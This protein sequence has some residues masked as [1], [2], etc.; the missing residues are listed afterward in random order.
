MRRNRRSL[1]HAGRSQRGGNER[2]SLSTR[3]IY[4]R[5]L[6]CEAL[7][8]RRLLGAYA[9][10][11]VLYC[12]DQNGKLCTISK[13]NGKVAVIGTMSETMTDIAF[14][15]KGL[16][17][18]IGADH[19]LYRI[20]PSNA[21]TS[22]IGYFSPD[23]NSLVFRSDGTLFAAGGT[24]AASLYT[25]N[26]STANTTLIGSL[27]GYGTAG[28]LA[29]GPSGRL[30]VT[31]TT[32]KLLRVN[33]SNGACTFIGKI[34]FDQVY[35]LAF[36]KDGT[37]YAVSNASEHLLRINT[38]TGEGWALAKFWGDDTVGAYGAD[39]WR[40]SPP[41]ISITD[42]AMTEGDS[43]TKT[44]SFKVSLTGA[45]VLG[46]S[47]NY[48]TS[49]GTATAG[50]DYDA[51]PTTTL[52]WAANT[53]GTKTVNVT[54]HGDTTVEWD[55]TFYVDLSGATN[56]TI[57]KPRGT[58]TIITDESFP[59][60]RIGDV[61][62]MEGNAGDTVFTFNV[63]MSGSNSLG[64]SVDFATSNGSATADVGTVINDYAPASGTLTWTAGDTSTKTI[65]VNVHGDTTIEDDER[66]YVTLSNPTNATIARPR[67][68]G[69]IVNDD[70]SV[71]GVL[72]VEAVA[73]KNGILESNDK[74][75][76]TWATDS[77]NGLASQT[78]MIDGTTMAPIKGPYGGLYYSCAIGAWSIGAH[79]YIITATDPN[80][81]V[82]SATSTFTVVAPIAPTI[83]SIV[84]AEAALPKNSKLESGEN[85]KITWSASSSNGIA[86][87]TVTVDGTAKTP[88]KGPY[89][90]LYYSCAIGGP[91]VAG[92]HT[93]KIKATDLK[94]VSTTIA[95]TF[96]VV[97]PPPPTI[98]SVLVTE[99]G[100]VKNGKLE[101]NESL[102]ITWAASSTIGIASQT[103]TVDGTAK[104]P[105]KGPYGGLYY[106]CAIGTY[107]AG[108][109][110]YTIKATDSQGV[111]STTTSTF[112]VASPLT[113]V[114]S[115]AAQATAESLIES[116]LAPIVAEAISRWETRLGSQ[117]ETTL[118]GV[119][120]ELADLSG[121][122]LGEALG[123]TI[124][125]DR[126]AAGYGWF[127]DPTPDDDTE[128]LAATMS[129]LSARKD[130]AAEQRADLLTAVMHE[131]GHLLG[132]ADTSADDLMGAMLP[133]GARRVPGTVA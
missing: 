86:S 40:N 60:V 104:T 92:S 70:I 10:T 15:P 31:T 110:T 98:N 9:L 94:G 53:T 83:T 35:G 68:S 88:I 74:L 45:N 20:D 127:V 38:T 23:L 7:E 63:T 120:I 48:A 44:F 81:V 93:Y 33:P 119:K 26:T 79:T 34:G 78:L 123:N 113:L 100:T 97:S 19:G 73:P 71:S 105:I 17:Y 62:M 29:F 80:G 82:A 57:A 30:Y 64:A 27:G 128:F 28:D 4:N 84:V 6:T 52:T 75:K 18:G 41:K 36:S 58:G 108:S 54:V 125:I 131:M 50:S 103:L 99:A 42:V 89:G 72:V 16:L 37:L 69:T 24:T 115:A 91:Y 76:I 21:V 107:A 8:D 111:S 102:K 77:P 14:G 13:I 116:Q 112:D 124:L 65:S 87:Q 126:D 66:F 122:T 121:K 2:S 67:G 3:S 85:L 12:G 1:Q 43:G 46:A 95:G 59:S 51:I 90:G 118:A 117:V 130:T 32:N 106:S 133:L 114:A 61:R 129:S 55:E 132:Y 56:A 101:P 11:D 25:I 22:R 5:R 39:I 47:V 49:D 96:T 109:H